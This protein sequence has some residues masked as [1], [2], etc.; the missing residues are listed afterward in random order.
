NALAP[1]MLRVK[2]VFI[3]G[4]ALAPSLGPAGCTVSC[5]Q[6]L[7]AL[8]AACAGVIGV[9]A[10]LR[11]QRTPPASNH[12]PFT[13]KGF[14]EGFKAVISNYSTMCYT[15]CMGLFFGSFM[16][17]LNS[18]QQIF[19]EL[20]NTG[21]MFTVYFGVLALLFGAASMVNARFVQK[22]G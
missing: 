3:R 7:R 22:W 15:L 16:G 9:W 11:L 21:K 12:L 4:P 8:C 6:Y 14:I 10:S 5:W 13:R 20:F 18:S 17:Y 1:L 2:L 19:Q